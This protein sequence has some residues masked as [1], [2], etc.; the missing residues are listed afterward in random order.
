MR[1]LLFG[2]GGT[3]HSSR[4]ATSVGGI[5]RI[6]ELG[7]GC[8]EVEFVRGVRMSEQSARQVAEASMEMGIVLSAHAPY[9]INLNAREPEKVKAS[10]DRVLQTARIASVSNIKSI[11]FHA[12]YY[13]GDPPEKVYQTVKKN[14]AEI[15]NQL[16]EENNH[17]QIRL[18]T[19]GAISEFGSLDEVLDLCAEMNGIAPCIDFSHLH[20]R[21]GEFNS[22]R[23]MTSILDRVKERLGRPALDD[24]HIHLSGIHYGKKGELKHLNLAESDLQ[25]TEIIQ[26]LTDYKVKGIVICE[27]PNLEEDALMLQETYDSLIKLAPPK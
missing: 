16:S 15:L 9:Y 6:A 12:A 25:Y 2:T 22:Y 5:E 4:T 14:L 8:M 21:N 1:G 11:V 24:M 18:E 17:V 10:Q 27:S 19:T 13:L 3:P 20:A 23:S 26:A 7:L